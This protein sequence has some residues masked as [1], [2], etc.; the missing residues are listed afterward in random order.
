[1]KQLINPELERWRLTSGPLASSEKSG[2]NGV[3][4]IPVEETEP[5]NIT[6]VCIVS[7]GRAA[8]LSDEQRGWEHVS[9]RVLYDNAQGERMSRVPFWSEMCH[10]KRLFWNDDEV[11]V[12]Y[13]PAESQYVNNHPDVLHLWRHRTLE[14]P[15]PP[16]ELI[17]I[18][19]AETD[20]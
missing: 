11:V 9:V 3:F 20:R 7:D 18:P 14:F 5:Y 8:G 2:Y 12:Q 1:M 17:G 6:Y 16:L 10:V 4:V 15:M 13:H 19:N